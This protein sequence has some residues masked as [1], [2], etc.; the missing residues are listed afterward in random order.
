MKVFKTL[1]GK[2]VEN[3]IEYIREYILIR[4]NIEILIGCDSQTKKK[5]TI[6]GVVVALYTPGK[7]A[8]VLCYRESTPKETVL[9]VKLINETWR[10]IELAE[11][12]R[13]NGLPKAKYIDIDLNP[14]PKYDSNKT[15]RQAIGL[16]EGM[17]YKARWKNH[18]A[19]VTR[20]ADHLVRETKRSK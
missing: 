9:S 13:E 17:G 1:Y 14:D 7:G 12:F 20:A 11:F 5:K 3:I 18:G 6:Y 4:D 2:P 10:S 16:V 15:L 19:M 8:H